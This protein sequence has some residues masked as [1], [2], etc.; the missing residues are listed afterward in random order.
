MWEFYGSTEGQFTACSPDEWLDRARHRRPGP[1]RSRLVRDRRR[2]RRLVPRPGHARFE[3]WRD[4]AKTAAAWR[5]DAFTV[6]DLG[7]LDDDGYLFL[8]GRRDDL[9]I[10]GGVNVYPAEVERVILEHPGVATTRCSASPTS[11]GASRVCAAVV[12]DVGADA[13][14]E[15]LRERLAA[16]KQPKRSSWSTTSPFAHGKDPPGRI[17]RRR[18]QPRLRSP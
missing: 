3:Y 1:P 10:T 17:W 4:P 13:L 14:D 15:F 9:I 5:G 16:Y 2:R 8:D 11:G 18:T 6:G 12:G 7:R